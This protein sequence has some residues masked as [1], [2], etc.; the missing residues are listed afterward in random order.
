MRLTAIALAALAAGPAGCHGGDAAPSDAAAPAPFTSTCTPTEVTAEGRAPAGRLG[1][2]TVVLP[3]GRKITP[4]GRVLDVGGFPLAMR[5]LPGG[6]Y[7]VVTD[8]AYGHEALRIVDTAASDPA[9]AV[10]SS[11]LYPRLASTP[12]D[13]ALFYGLA[14]SADGRH[15]WASC[16]GHDPV[17]PQVVGISHY[18]T[19]DAYDLVGDPPQLQPAASGPIRLMFNPGNAQHGAAQPRLPAGIALSAD[20]KL[21]YVACQSDSTLAIVDLASGAEV[22][23]AALPGVG[24]YDVAIDPPSHTAFVS[25]WGGLTQSPGHF[26][27]GVVAV[28][29]ADPA[30]PLPAAAPLSTGKAAEAELLLA[31]KLY[32]TNADADTLSVVDVASRSVR[33]LPVTAGELVGA[34]PNSIAV[35]A[36][37]GRLYVANAGTNS[38]LAVDLASLLPLGSIPTAWY[39]TAVTVLE[40]GALAIASAKGLGLGPIDHSPAGDAYGYMQ[41]VVQVVP[42]PSAAELTAGATR[43]AQNLDRP[44]SYQATP[45][46]P[47]DGAAARFPLPL[48]GSGHGPIE[49]VFLIVRENK[50]YDAV[51][52]DLE[53]AGG[54]RD[55]VMFPESMTPNAHALARAFVNLDNFYSLAEQ[56]LQG[57]EWTTAAIANDYTEKAWSTTWGRAYRPE[58]A[59]SSGAL[60]RLAIPGSGTIWTHLDAAG[61]RYKNYGEVVNAAGATTSLDPRYPGVVFN[62]TV[63]D[64]DK[65]EYLAQQLSEPTSIVPF[66]YIV[67][68]NDHTYGTAPGKPTPQSMVADNDEATGRFVEALSHSAL[69]G[70][71]IVFVVEDDPADGG[72]HVEPH[73]SIGL[74]VSPWVRRGLV[75]HGNYDM[76]ALY[77]T[78]E[79]LLGVGPMNLNDAH[80]AAMYDLFSPT[81]DFTPY[82]LRPRTVPEGNNSES[83][84]LAEES[85]GIDFSQPDQAPL[86]RI[87]WKAMRDP[88]G[89]PPWHRPGARLP[90]DND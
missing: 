76:P 29:V 44:R 47:T 8:G 23:R 10:A 16:G 19:I 41:G 70:S 64:I 38:V 62:L 90:L 15:L 24:A 26:I 51:L 3:G 36:E 21:L 71:S 80:A 73:R 87:L 42:R 43:V 34:A 5:A 50:T 61:V 11:A 78:V 35:D 12:Q 48:D 74:V 33:S 31:G 77:R 79:L 25:M 66:S 58:S 55:L 39:P 68:P 9:A 22:G 32:V 52:G 67:L 2:G 54:D 82:T 40:G 30:R 57:H 20:E 56:S 53:G 69:W 27:D 63:K 60:E 14:L 7:L 83:A 4:A 18:N 75:S 85:A 81:P 72:D 28:D 37:A 17:D 6:R 86:G 13:P 45:R 46:C 49:H 65:V 88:H 1:D 84:P 59:F 89:E